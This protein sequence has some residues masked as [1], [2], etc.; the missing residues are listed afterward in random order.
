[1]LSSSPA[2]LSV[3]KD[4]ITDEQLNMVMITIYECFPSFGRRMVDGYLIALGKRV[5][6]RRIF[7]SFERVICPLGATYGN[8]HIECRIYSVPG[9]NSQWHHDGQHGMSQ[10]F[11][12]KL[13][14]HHYPRRFSKRGARCMSSTHLSSPILST[15]ATEHQ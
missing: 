3:N 5:P 15:E 4:Q 7:E 10:L 13:P 12:R 6:R 14:V 9:P 8:R 2:P 1:M 11:C